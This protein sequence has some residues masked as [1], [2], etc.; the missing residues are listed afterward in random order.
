MTKLR[1]LFSKFCLNPANL[2]YSDIEKI[3]LA[4]KCIKISAKGSHVKFKHQFSK[5]DLII[6]IHNH[7]CKEFYKKT[8]LKF[9][10]D[11][12]LELYETIN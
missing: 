5:F 3:L 11:N 9:I 12:Q 7:D 10:K 8:A 4:L 6:P 1:K 2:H